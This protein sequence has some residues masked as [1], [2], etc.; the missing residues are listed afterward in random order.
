MLSHRGTQLSDL[1]RSKEL[2]L[3]SSRSMELLN[4]GILAQVYLFIR[5][6]INHSRAPKDTTRAF[7]AI[8]IVVGL[9]IIAAALVVGVRNPRVVSR[10]DSSY[11]AYCNLTDRLADW[12]TFQRI[13]QIPGHGKM[14]F[15]ILVFSLAPAMTFILSLAA[16]IGD[17]QQLDFVS[18]V[19]THSMPTFAAAMLGTQRDIIQSWY[20]CYETKIARSKKPIPLSKAIAI[21]GPL[22]RDSPLPRLNTLSSR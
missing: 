11:P 5:A 4:V 1:D 20:F 16:E 14:V 12:E 10:V 9:V 22:A 2:T 19:L 3:K 21:Q 8:V 17:L 15:R 7:C 13:R 18:I 6:N